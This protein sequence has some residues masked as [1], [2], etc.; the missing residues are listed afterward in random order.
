MAQERPLI[1]LL[2][3]WILKIIGFITAIVA[4]PNTLSFLTAKVKRVLNSYF[5]VYFVYCVISV[6]KYDVPGCSY[7]SLYI[8]ISLAQVQ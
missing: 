4:A 8:S 1:V 2:L 6:P 3:F 7:K 5:D